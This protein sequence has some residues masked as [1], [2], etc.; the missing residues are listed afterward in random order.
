LSPESRRRTH[1]N[2]L[3]VIDSKDERDQLAV[4]DAPILLDFIDDA[5]REHFRKLRRELDAL[6]TPYSVDPRLVRGL[7]Y[8]TR[9]LFEIKG[10]PEKLGAGSTLLGGGR[11]DV[12]VAELGGPQVPAIGFAAGLERLLIASAIEAT[13]PVVDALVA[14][15]GPEALTAGLV[16]ARELRARGVRCEIDTRGSTLKS[17]LR[18]ANALGA[19]MV[20]ILGTSELAD[21][22]LQVKDLD[23]HTQERMPRDEALRFVVDRLA[24][25]SRVGEARPIDPYRD[26]K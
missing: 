2:P 16:L 6:G 17:Q 24:L 1:T 25:A 19:R 13:A 5:D 11:Y 10:A 22:V 12:L 14:P 26:G 21:G 15:V 20:L 7:D 8:Y 4:A 18:R 23:R 9:T 3:R